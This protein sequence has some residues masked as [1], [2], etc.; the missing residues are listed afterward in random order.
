MCERVERRRRVAS[1][2]LHYLPESR[3]HGLDRLC[4]RHGSLSKFRSDTGRLCSA[5]SGCPPFPDVVARMRPSDSLARVGRRLWF[6][7]PPPYRGAGAASARSLAARPAVPAPASVRRVGDGSPGLR[8]PGRRP[9]TGQ[10]LSGKEVARIP[11]PPPP[12]KIRTAG[13][14]QYGFKA[15]LSGGAFPSMGPVKPAPGIP[16]PGVGLHPPFVRA[17]TRSTLPLCVGRL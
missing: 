3:G 1:C 10:G 9:Q 16:F 15:G 14:P 11:V 12:L 17:F 5:G 13:F 4:S 2:A 7:S 6:P 8:S